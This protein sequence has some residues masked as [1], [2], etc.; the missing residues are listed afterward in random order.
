MAKISVTDVDGRTARDVTHPTL[1]T[2]PASATTA[3]VRAYF[4]TSSSR[5]LAAVTDGDRYV[6]AIDA[7]AFAAQAPAPGLAARELV[8]DHPTVAPDAPAAQARDLALA[9]ESRRV[10]VVDGDGRLVGV[11][12]I[13]KTRTGFCGSDDAV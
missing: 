8:H 13:D 4:A 2:V 3:E 6:G 9:T 10:P 11:V 5:R 1:T 7:E 12:A